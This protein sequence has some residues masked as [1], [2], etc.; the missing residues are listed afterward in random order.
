MILEFSEAVPCCATI[1]SFTDDISAFRSSI[2]FVKS[3]DA[4][5][6]AACTKTKSLIDHYV[7]SEYFKFWEVKLK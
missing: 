1:S 2:F 4:C 7:F 3:C 5:F 6:A